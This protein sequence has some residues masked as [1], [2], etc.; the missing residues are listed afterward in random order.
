MMS[1]VYRKILRTIQG[2]PTRC[3][4]SALGSLDVP[5]MVLQ[6]QICFANSLAAMSSSDF[7]RQVL[8]CRLSLPNCTVIPVWENSLLDLKL[9]SLHCLLSKSRGKPAWKRSIKRYC[10]SINNFSSLTVANTIRYPRCLLNLVKPL[11]SGSSVS[12]IVR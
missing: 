10:V 2:L 9:P 11:P 4:N 8:E 5:S 3:P 7:P 6:R 1:R 12:K